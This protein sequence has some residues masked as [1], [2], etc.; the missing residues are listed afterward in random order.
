MKIL[1]NWIESQTHGEKGRALAALALH[2]GVTE[3]T[4]HRYAAGKTPNRHVAKAIEQ[5]IKKQE[6]GK[7]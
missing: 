2:T 4:L 6:A 1:K 7:C 3:S 5:Y